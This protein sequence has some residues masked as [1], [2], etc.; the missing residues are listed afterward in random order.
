L[1]GLNYLKGRDDPTALAEEEYPEWLWKCLDVD[2]KGKTG[3][4]LEGDEFCMF[5]PQWT[6]IRCY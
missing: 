5:M 2:K 4:E 3:D 1:K 6:P